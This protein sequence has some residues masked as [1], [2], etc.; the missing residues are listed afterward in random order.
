[1][2]HGTIQTIGNCIIQTIYNS[3]QMISTHSRRSLTQSRRYLTHTRESF[4]TIQMI[5][6]SIQTIR[7]DLQ[8]V[9]KRYWIVWIWSRIVWIMSRIGCPQGVLIC[10]LLD[11]LYHFTY[12]HKQLAGARRGMICGG[13]KNRRKIVQNPVFSFFQGQMRSSSVSNCLKLLN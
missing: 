1:M 6:G 8:R 4:D 5:L 2:E 10:V 11:S 9:K 13:P 12:I 3:I 7:S